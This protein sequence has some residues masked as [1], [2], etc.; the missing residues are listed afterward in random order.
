MAISRTT[1][2]TPRSRMRRAIRWQ[3]CPP[4]LRTTIWFT[5]GA[6]LPRT[7]Q[8]LGLLEH[9][10]LGL[11]GGRDDD[12]GLLQLA[13]RLRP[14][15]AHAGAN[16]ADEIQ[17]A[18]FRERRPEQDLVE[19]A[20]DAHADTHAAR[21]VR[22]RR[23]HAPVVAAA[24]GLG[25]TRE[26]RADHHGIGA[27]G[28]RLAHV[29]ARRHAAVGDDGNVA[30]GLLVVEI[31]RGGR[32]RRRRHLRYAEAEHLAARAGG[33][34][35]HADQQRVGTHLHQLQARFVRH[36]V[37]DHER[38]RERLL[39][40]AQVDRR[41]LGGDV[42]RGGD[43][44]LDDEDVGAR[45][46]RDL[47][48]A[49]GALRDRRHD[50]GPAALFD[51]ANALVDQLFLDR[52]AVDRLDD[53][54]RFFLAG[55]DDAVEDVLGVRVAREHALEIE[56]G[57]ASEASHLDRQLGPD[58]AVHGGGD[59]RYA[60][61]VATQLPGDV[62]LIGIDGESARHERDIV[63]TV[64]C[65]GLAPSPDPHSHVVPPGSPGVPRRGPYPKYRGRPADRS[66]D[67]VQYS[68]RPRGCQSSALRHRPRACVHRM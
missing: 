63:E 13:D 38:D 60:V 36:D 32:V 61:L 29:A 56:H 2:C 57:G 35:P 1:A 18:V 30:A 12:L 16:G 17:R 11:D 43:R 22:V 51:L 45:L 6:A 5:G 15:R 40:L 39:E 23:G 19:R 28:E 55:R 54:G 24:G 64:R 68:G 50:G 33:A 34:R 37:A 49:L 31:A 58:H 62:D 67:L 53:L 59:D 3:Y 10:A 27:R 52:L 14:H 4:A 47:A 66:L 20:R 9:L 48:K 25:G 46:L 65:P 21:Q 8:L 41:V 42:P 26:G 44:G 7:P